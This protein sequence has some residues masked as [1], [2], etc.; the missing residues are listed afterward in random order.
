M[1]NFE[2]TGTLVIE[3]I[4]G[5]QAQ[6]E[7]EF[8]VSASAAANGSSRDGSR[9]LSTAVDHLDRGLDLDDTRNDLLRELIDAQETDT[10]QRATSSAIGGVI[11]TAI[12]LGTTTLV[13]KALTSVSSSLQSFKVPEVDPGDVVTT[14]AT[15]AAANVIDDAAD[16]S[17]SD[18]VGDPATIG[19]AAVIGSPAAL[20]AAA[21]ID[22]AA[23][24]KA[25]DVASAVDLDAGDVVSPAE[26]S[27]ADVISV[28]ATITVSQL[29]DDPAG[30]TAAKLI[31]DAADIA[32]EDVVGDPASISAS[33][34]IKE[35]AGVSKTEIL[36]ALGIA[37]TGAGLLKDIGSGGSSGSAGGGSA[38][39]VGI[40]PVILPQLLESADR[41]TSRDLIPKPRGQRTASAQSTLSA[42][43]RRAQRGGGNVEV[44]NDVT[45]DGMTER[46]T[47]SL[48]ERRLDEF[49][50]GLEQDLNR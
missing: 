26:V 45:V 43:D 50:R 21:V 20:S 19:A 49:T 18:L 29:I 25:P 32:A 40:P 22:E 42:R 11:G 10:F 41:L 47:E 27:A 37:G 2:A 12:T 16:I 34:L 36:A 4:E 35:G 38:V 33:D 17:A 46:E 3:S 28:A 48:I 5:A 30:V 7:D 8:S 39:G 31:G 23:S 15:V 44:T 6:L 14:G 24:L 1:T 13:G 9:H